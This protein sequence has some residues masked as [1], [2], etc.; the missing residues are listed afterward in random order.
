MMEPLP[1]LR[2]GDFRGSGIFHQV[3]DAHRPRSAQPRIQ[4]L[5]ADVD[6]EPPTRLRDL[7]AFYPDIEQVPRSDTDLLAQTFLLMRLFLQD[8]VK[9]LLC[10]RDEVRVSDPRP[11]K[12]IARLA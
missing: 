3:I 4:V 7:P 12:A 5:Q 9:Y 2:A 8:S 1:D 6:V 11:V 10:N